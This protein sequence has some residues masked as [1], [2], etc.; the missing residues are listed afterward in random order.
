VTCWTRRNVVRGVLSALLV[1]AAGAPLR[2]LAQSATDGPQT[3]VDD[4]PTSNG[5]NFGGAEWMRIPRIGVDAHISDVTITG[6]YYDVPWFD[7]G[8]HVDSHDPGEPGNSIFN[9]HVVTIDAGQV[10]RHL[11]QRVEG[12]AVYVYT[13]AYRLDW[14]VT[15]VFS[16]SAEDSTFLQETDAPRITL[17]TCSGQFNPI[18]RSYAERLVAFGELVNV[19][20]RA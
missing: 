19:V 11:D 17:Y 2:A 10:F 3:D 12:G 9:G 5:S 8:H 15:D 6:G 18:E 13:R 16:V 7:V 14:V 4:D 1:S 20:H